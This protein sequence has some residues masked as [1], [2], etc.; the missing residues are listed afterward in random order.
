MS[1]VIETPVGDE[2]MLY[3]SMEQPENDGLNDSKDVSKDDSDS[4]ALMEEQMCSSNDHVEDGPQ[5]PQH[6]FVLD[7][8]SSLGKREHD[9]V[10]DRRLSEPSVTDSPA[11]SP[12]RHG[13]RAFGKKKLK[14]SARQRKRQLERNF[15]S[16]FKPGTIRHRLN[17]LQ[18]N[19][20]DQLALIE[21][22]LPQT[23]HRNMNL[24][25]FIRNKM[26]QHEQHTQNNASLRRSPSFRRSPERQRKT[27]LKGM[28]EIKEAPSNQTEMAE[29]M[30]FA[31]LETPQFESSSSNLNHNSS[32]GERSV[33]ITFSHAGT[34]PLDRSARE[35]RLSKF[36][37]ESP[38]PSPV[39]QEKESEKVELPADAFLPALPV[40]ETKSD[41]APAAATASTTTVEAL[42]LAVVVP[43]QQQ[44]PSHDSA[45]SLEE[46][47]ERG[48]VRTYSDDNLTHFATISATGIIKDVTPEKKKQ[49]EEQQPKEEEPVAA[50]VAV[51]AEEPVETLAT[52][53]PEEATAATSAAPLT[54]E[55]PQAVEPAAPETEEALEEVATTPKVI[56]EP[57]TQAVTEEAPKVTE[58]SAT[59]AVTE[60]APKVIEE[61][62]TLAVTEEAPATEEAPKAVAEEVPTTEEVATPAA[63]EEAPTTEEP[64]S[65][66]AIEEVAT[67]APTEEPATSTETEEVPTT[68]EPATPAVTEEPSTPAV[69]EEVSTTEEPATPAVVEEA[70]ATE[71][72]ATPAATEEPEEESEHSVEVAGDNL[73]A[74]GDHDEMEA[75]SSSV[76]E[77]VVESPEEPL[78]TP[79][80]G[81]VAETPAETVQEGIVSEPQ[82]PQEGVASEPQAEPVHEGVASEEEVPQEGVVEAPAAP[83]QEGVASEEQEAPQEEDH[84]SVQVKESASQIPDIGED[85]PSRGDSPPVQ[86]KKAVQVVPEAKLPIEGVVSEP[87]GVVSQPEGV[88]SEPEPE[89]MAVETT[90]TAP[91][92]P[93]APVAPVVSEGVAEEEPADAA[94]A[95]VIDTNAAPSDD[96]V[97]PSTPVGDQSVSS[98]STA[99]FESPRGLDPVERARMEQATP[100]K[101]AESKPATPPTPD[102]V[103]RA[104]LEQQTPVKRKHEEDA[105][106]S[107]DAASKQPKAEASDEAGATDENKDSQNC[108]S[109]MSVMDTELGE[110]EGKVVKKQVPLKENRKLR[111]ADEVGKD[112]TKEYVIERE[113]NYA[114]RIVVML[115]SPRD[116]KFEFLHAEYPLDESTTVQVL[117]EQVPLLATNDA[118]RTKKFNALLQT[119]TSRQLD[120]NLA[121]QDYCF[122]ESEIVLG[123][124]DDFTVANMTKMA[125]PLLLNKKLMKTVKQA[126]RKGRGLKTVQSGEEWRK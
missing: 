29:I 44:Q 8:E 78:V 16:D 113:A 106:T 31:P 42:D 80:E 105:T 32:S 74:D 5:K 67:P 36:L 99:S 35:W 55:E 52:P 56:E 121:L 54:E 108:P 119:E 45:A 18:H 47:R 102:A 109:P 94:P 95:M 27:S 20:G 65:P 39:Q 58:E 38:P 118:F 40:L 53:T 6:I 3:P 85:T 104:R 10:F 96:S 50:V 11:A 4:N 124:P 116:R 120:N 68:E 12:R 92:D 70:P 21:E 91:Q 82:A 111:F 2:N 41:D 60:E 1:V 69:T 90:E 98:A 114:S 73:E 48:V 122:K 25:T 100:V 22:S 112:L 103:E 79:S 43:E 107:G 75:S 125:V 76:P 126:I 61:P 101:T 51:A 24:E 33:G 23:F 59:S 17:F 46:K 37:E 89:S 57:A 30:T 7:R 115:L 84:V 49:Q 117:L 63:T 19:F 14:L 81:V 66:A 15:G 13:S 86:A 83:V 72:V 26:E 93:P 97:V 62:A 110:G 28:P 64:A 34:F 9:S 88:V 77:G 71:E 87:E 123:I